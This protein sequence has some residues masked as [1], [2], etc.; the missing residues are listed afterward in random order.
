M[1]FLVTTN[2][3]F[4]CI[5]FFFLNSNCLWLNT[6]T[7]IK[8]THK[9]NKMGKHGMNKGRNSKIRTRDGDTRDSD[10]REQWKGD[11]TGTMEGDPREQGKGIQGNNGRRSKGTMEGDT[12]EQGKGI[13][14]NKGRRSK[15]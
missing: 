4:K 12:R 2:S 10:P 13:Q 8:C 7:E 14:G 5:I 11:E 9:G 6:M 3:E 1:P 15:E